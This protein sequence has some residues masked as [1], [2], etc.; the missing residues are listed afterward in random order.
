MMT[1]SAPA[2]RVARASASRCDQKVESSVVRKRIFKGYLS[3][4]EDVPRRSLRMEL[5]QEQEQTLPSLGTLGLFS[6]VRR[7]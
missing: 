1:T 7:K 4:S 3:S 5:R 2:A 6:V